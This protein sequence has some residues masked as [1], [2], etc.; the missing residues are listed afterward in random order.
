MEHG[1]SGG[2]GSEV[3]D[4]PPPSRVPDAHLAAA[5]R[6]RARA[7]AGVTLGADPGV[8]AGPGMG[9]HVGPDASP[10]V[11][12]ETAPRRETRAS[13]EA[14]MSCGVRR[15]PPPG[16]RTLAPSWRDVPIRSCGASSAA[17]VL[18][19][20]RCGVLRR[21]RGRGGSEADHQHRGEGSNG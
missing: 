21:L 9:P 1:E 18:P 5:S 10:D 17:H 8:G 11:G 20:R 4:V 13:G 2:C 16:E 12:P 3:T 15:T 14:G 6:V 19:C 7:E